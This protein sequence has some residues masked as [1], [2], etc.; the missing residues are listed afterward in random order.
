MPIIPCVDDGATDQDRGGDCGEQQ[1]YRC[2][3]VEHSRTISATPVPFNG[4][5]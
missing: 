3:K 1:K 4:G 5:F 2:G